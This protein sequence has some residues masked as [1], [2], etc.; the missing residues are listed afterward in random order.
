MRSKFIIFICLFSLIFILNGLA[1]ASN[2]KVDIEEELTLDFKGSRIRVET[3]NGNY[4]KIDTTYLVREPYEIITDNNVISF[5]KEEHLQNYPND[6]DDNKLAFTLNEVYF[7][8]KIPKGMI[9]NIYA[10]SAN[11]KEGSLL[12]SIFAKNARVRGCEFLNGFIGEGEK[13]V[14]RDSHFL[15]EKE[16]D[17]D[18]VETDRYNHIWKLIINFLFNKD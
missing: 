11:I 4:V 3:W 17:Y 8:I 13:I 7:E 12:K 14:I 10:D 6:L 1:S 9:V 5:D 15:G 16:L 2:I 18:K